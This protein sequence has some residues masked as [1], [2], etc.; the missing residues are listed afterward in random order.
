M[1]IEDQ[2][3]NNLKYDIA[4]CNVLPT[5]IEFFVIE[6]NGFQDEIPLVI[7]GKVVSIIK[8]V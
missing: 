5:Q 4:Y 2:Y 7:D 3:I 6:F 8:V 1:N